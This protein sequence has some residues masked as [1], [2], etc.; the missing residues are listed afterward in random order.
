MSTGGASSK[1]LSLGGAALQTP[2]AVP[3]SRP[4]KKSDRAQNRFNNQQ[5]DGF[6]AFSAG[7]FLPSVTSYHVLV[8]FLQCM[9]WGVNAG[10]DALRSVTY[11]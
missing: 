11:K 9:G 2:K 5:E 8:I 6:A 3:H 1:R 7:K 10:C 4:I